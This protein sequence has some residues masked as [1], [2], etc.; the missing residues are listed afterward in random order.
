MNLALSWNV[1]YG[2]KADPAQSAKQLQQAPAD[3]Q[4]E[5]ATE[6]PESHPATTKTKAKLAHRIDVIVPP[7]MNLD[8]PKPEVP[9]SEPD[10]SQNTSLRN[11]SVTLI[12]LQSAMWATASI[13]QAK[14]GG[15]MKPATAVWAPKGNEVRARPNRGAHHGRCCH[16]NQAAGVGYSFDPQRHHESQ[17]K[18]SDKQKPCKP[19]STSIVRPAADKTLNPMI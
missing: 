3:Q 2:S 16:Y 10:A 4:S 15:D 12:A 9:A 8:C 18:E 14:C 17:R 11:P 13:G 6:A 7:A 19:L 5:I 1:R